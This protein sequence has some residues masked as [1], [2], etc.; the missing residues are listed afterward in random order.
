M[1]PPGP[2]SSVSRRRYQASRKAVSSS[3]RPPWRARMAASASDRR[4]RQSTPSGC[5][6]RAMGWM[7]ARPLPP[8]RDRR[9]RTRPLLHNGGGE[10]EVGRRLASAVG[11]D[12][13]PP[14][15]RSTP[16]AC[17]G[18]RCPGPRRVHRRLRS[19]DGRALA[20][21]GKHQQRTVPGPLPRPGDGRSAAAVLRLAAARRRHRGAPGHPVVRLFAR[22]SAS[23]GL[24]IVYL[25][26]VAPDGTVRNVTDRWL[27]ARHRR[28][29]AG[30]PP[31][32]QA[33]PFRTYARGDMAPLT[34]DVE[35]LL[36]TC[37]PLRPFRRRHAIRVA[38][39]GADKDNLVAVAR[40]DAPR[41]FIHRG[42]LISP[43]S[44]SPWSVDAGRRACAG[45]GSW[46]STASPRSRRRHRPLRK[47][48]GARRRPQLPGTDRRR[49]QRCRAI[50]GG[51]QRHRGGERCHRRAVSSGRRL[52][53][54]DRLVAARHPRVRARR[55]LDPP[56]RR[57]P[58]LQPRRPRARPR[59]RLSPRP[60]S[61]SA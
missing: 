16:L 33:P 56:G 15:G 13:V 4:C 51:R 36:S 31:Y 24:F 22:S 37:S 50:D 54:R 19:R 25:D 43:A 12:V 32:W 17:C 23:D 48:D 20:L 8:G 14:P 26:D 59:R 45:G 28:L 30:Q 6:L 41:I 44:N 1:R 60:R 47:L 29:A 34:G 21:F 61:R 42:V 11:D 57:A 55:V 2:G 10:M 52:R 39:A 53:Q 27:R 7:A 18:R 49:G 3:V 40:E 5:S 58:A 9:R 38:I 35:E 46:T